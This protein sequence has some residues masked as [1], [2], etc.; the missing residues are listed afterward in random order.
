MCIYVYIRY[1]SCYHCAIIK[2]TF[3]PDESS[4]FNNSFFT[5]VFDFSVFLSNLNMEIFFFYVVLMQKCKVIIGQISLIEKAGYI[6]FQL[7]FTIRNKV[8]L[9]ISLYL[10]WDQGGLINYL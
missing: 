1:V 7:T 8:G 2:Y 9:C 3:F 10:S 6:Y 5:F 4:I